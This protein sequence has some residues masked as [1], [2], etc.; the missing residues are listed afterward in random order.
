[1]LNIL[2]A[3]QPE[4]V[5]EDLDTD[6]YK[7]RFMTGGSCPKSPKS[8]NVPLEPDLHTMGKPGIV[9]DQSAQALSCPP[10]TIIFIYDDVLYSR[11]RIL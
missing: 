8:K 9:G 11:E 7:G 10:L 1:M 4:S 2:Y 5:I 6:E 3:K